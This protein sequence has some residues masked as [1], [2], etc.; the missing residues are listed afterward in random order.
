MARMV[1][2]EVVEAGDVDREEL[3]FALYLLVFVQTHPSPGLAFR[4]ALGLLAMG[5][6]LWPA[7]RRNPWVWAGAAAL[8]IPGLVLRYWILANHTFATVFLILAFAISRGTRP[9]QRWLLVRWLVAGILAAAAVQKLV[10]PSYL[11]GD[12]LGHEILT[13]QSFRRVLRRVVSGWPETVEA[14]REA[15]RAARDSVGTGG[16]P[17]PLPYGGVPRLGAVVAFGW[18]VVIY[19]LA[20]SVAVALRPSRWW[21]LTGLLVF[22][23]GTALIQNEAQFLA[24]MSIMGLILARRGSPYLRPAFALSA[25]LLLAFAT[26]GVV[27]P[28]V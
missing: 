1:G 25:V 18:L 6:V 20:L 14:N 11:A 8:L 23:W 13:G 2:A 15:F 24:L 21:T 27:I 26:L 4:G 28:G 5:M 17:P 19:E 9:D 12:Y 7:L 10:T 3:L 22:V 16:P